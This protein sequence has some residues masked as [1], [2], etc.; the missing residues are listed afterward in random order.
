MLF[1]S[2][3]VALA[4]SASSVA[5]TPI[6][7]RK[8]EFIFPTADPFYVAPAN[9]SAYAYGEVIRERSMHTDVT[10][11]RSSIQIL[12]KTKDG[13]G[14]DDATV[15]TVFAPLKVAPGVPKILSIQFA[16]ESLTQQAFLFQYC[17]IEVEAGARLVRACQC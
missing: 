17:M 3:F 2:A 7:A 5:A 1:F 6:E 9:L 16:R 8:T 14:R 12:Y 13:V 15:T 11:H 4:V 10:G